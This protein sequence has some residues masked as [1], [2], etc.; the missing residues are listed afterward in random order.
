MHR[1][2]KILFECDIHSRYT[3]RILFELSYPYSRI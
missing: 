2:N 3:E 1:F